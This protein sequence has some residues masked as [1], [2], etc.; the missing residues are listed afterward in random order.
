M[1]CWMEPSALP[2]LK[3]LKQI[4]ARLQAQ[5]ERWSSQ[6][7][8]RLLLDPNSDDLRKLVLSVRKQAGSP[9]E[10]VLFHYNGHGVPRPTGNGEVWV[11]NRGYTQY[12]PVSMYDVQAWMGG[13]AGAGVYVID[14]NAAGLVM[15]AFLHFLKQRRDKLSG[16][17]ATASAPA[18][19]VDGAAGDPAADIAQA[20]PYD[21]RHI[22]L[23][24]CG[25]AESLPSLSYLPADLFTS[26]L[27]TPIKTAL[28][29]ALSRSTLC[30]LQSS[31]IDSLPGMKK[32]NNR[33]T[34]YGELNWIF[35][36]IT[37]AIAWST[38]PLP[39]FQ[40]LFRHDLLVA[41]LFRNYWLAERI[42]HAHGVHTVTH[43][44]LPATHSH[45]MWA[46]WDVCVD[47]TMAQ[48]ERYE[49]KHDA[50]VFTP[51]AFFSQ[52]LTAF[53]VYLDYAA[54]TDPP[55][56]QLPV[57]LQV[58]LSSDHRKRALLLLARYIDKGG[59]AVNSA[60]NVGVFPYVLKLL[61]SVDEAMRPC[62][63]F[64]W[65]KIVAWDDTVVGDL[66]KSGGDYV[67]YFVRHM[68]G[69]K[70]DTVRERRQQQRDDEAR[71]N[72]DD[73]VE[74]KED[75]K[76]DRDGGDGQGLAA[77]GSGSNSGM[78]SRHS[79]SSS[80]IFAPSPHFL[81]PAVSQAATPTG[82]P[83]F[84]PI[85]QLHPPP[86][87]PAKQS[88]AI[89][90]PHAITD[91]VSS[92]LSTRLLQQLLS[93]F[94]LTTIAKQ[95]NPRAAAAM[96]APPLT[97]LTLLL[98]PQMIAVSHPLLRRWLLLLTSAL[99]SSSLS[100]LHSALSDHV[101]DA[102]YPLLFDPMPEV[103][104]TALLALSS[105]IVPPNASKE[106]HRIDFELHLGYVMSA[107]SADASALVRR[108]CVI[109]VGEVVWSHSE[110]FVAVSGSSN[111]RQTAKKVFA[112]W[113]ALLRLCRD[114]HPTVSAAATRAAQVGEE[115]SAVRQPA[116][117]NDSVA[118][119]HGHQR[120]ASIQPHQR[121]LSWRHRGQRHGQT[122]GERRR[123]EGD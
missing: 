92:L 55:P 23:C 60:L 27:T 90:A 107:L 6:C 120:A 30:R 56:L 18:T 99:L 76:A 53:E 67:G 11:Y 35:T 49:L 31:S 73:E 20:D 74:E 71:D 89:T 3:A 93:A 116:G 65:A 119:Q 7:A 113:R 42:M 108:E 12:I 33:R 16:S 24:A 78:A 15:E 40:Q 87:S 1:Q 44:Q 57:L 25:A 123:E 19:A 83:S 38:L 8:N 80:L 58:L 109:A 95:Q 122:E 103:R 98:Q 100:I 105:F 101:A 66:S 14:C 41:S 46:A 114:A 112:V 111:G 5:Y 21:C 72:E 2:P 4:G 17:A 91:A 61:Q 96:L 86:A 51:S 75:R 50:A 84:L 104:A 94:I 52:Q 45:P 34:A 29:F 10:R 88:I 77:S 69:W 54:E 36:A 26:C 81:S 64:I 62:L 68:L 118:T 9:H 115:Q 70:G 48:L 32:P 28:R 85:S 121:R 37:D 110:L 79:T 106:Q 47:V 13:V 59:W 117:Q 97:S 63:V 22:F 82:T 39:L 43:P 102:V